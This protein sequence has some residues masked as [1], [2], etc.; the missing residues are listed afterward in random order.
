[1]LWRENR[2]GR[3]PP[4]GRRN[5]TRLS[6]GPLINMMEASEHGHCDDL[7]SLSASIRRVCRPCAGRTLSNRAMRAPVVEVTDILGQDLLQ[8]ALIED[9]HV[10]Q[11]LRPD[12][13]HPAFGDGVAPRR[14][15]GCAGLGN[16]ETTHPTIEDG[17]IACAAHQ[18]SS[19][20]GDQKRSCRRSR[21]WSAPASEL[22]WVLLQGCHS[23]SLLSPSCYS[24]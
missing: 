1:L 20:P 12:R 4:V 24:I 14:S 19:N 5:W 3:R 11:A 18:S 21:Y 13:S 22:L 8:M 2:V 9:E 6:C 7:S 17:A 15:D 16:A 10:I 23:A